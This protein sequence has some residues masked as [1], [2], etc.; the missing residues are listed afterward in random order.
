MSVRPLD[1]LSALD[2][3]MT[4]YPEDSVHPAV[5]E[6]LL[7]RCAGEAL[8]MEWLFD[9]RPTEVLFHEQLDPTPEALEMFLELQAAAADGF[10]LG[11]LYDAL[12][13]RALSEEVPA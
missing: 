13:E 2:E 1:M 11:E 7:F 6:F 9:E 12:A 8:D 4:L 3:L 10:T 5:P